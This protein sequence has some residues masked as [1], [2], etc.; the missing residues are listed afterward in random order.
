MQ[1]VHYLYALHTNKLT[2]AM[3]LL[4][5]CRL[6]VDHPFQNTCDSDFCRY[7]P[8]VMHLYIYIHNKENVCRKVRMTNIFSSDL[9][10]IHLY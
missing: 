9:A 5:S 10:K 7:N 4:F 2:M 8:F 3:A 6:F 1:F